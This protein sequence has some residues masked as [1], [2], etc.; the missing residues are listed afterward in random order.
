MR[1]MTLYR[2]KMIPDIGYKLFSIFVKLSK[3]WD[4]E[5]LHNKLKAKK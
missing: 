1:D 2:A 4:V 5:V 3:K